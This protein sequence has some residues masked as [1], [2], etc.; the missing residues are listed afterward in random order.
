MRW[1]RVLVSEKLTLTADGAEPPF[2]LTFPSGVRLDG[3]DGRDRGGCG[4]RRGTVRPS[5]RH[6]LG[7]A[8]GSRTLGSGTIGSRGRLA[9]VMHNRAAS[10]E[11]D[12]VHRAVAA[13]DKMAA[14]EQHDLTRRRQAEKA[15][16]RGLV[17]R[18]SGRYDRW[19]SVIV[20]LG[21]GRGRSRL[22]GRRGVGGKTVNLVEVESVQSNL[23]VVNSACFSRGV[24]RGI[25]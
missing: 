12:H 25:P 16:R 8:F 17:L 19:V 4:A 6:P 18:G 24:E 3:R 21:G 23:E 15:L 1:D 2:G 13:R 14:W 22:G 10:A 9:L 11:F 20:Q 7:V 5:G